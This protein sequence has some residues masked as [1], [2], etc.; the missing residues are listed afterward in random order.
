MFERADKLQ[1]SPKSD[2]QS[3]Q[4]YKWS[5]TAHFGMTSVLKI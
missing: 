4:E 5:T 1:Y 3:N 2:E